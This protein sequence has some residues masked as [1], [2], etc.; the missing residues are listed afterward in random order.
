MMTVFERIPDIFVTKY[1]PEIV[2]WARR[3]SVAPMLEIEL[4]DATAA[5]LVKAGMAAPKVRITAVI[6][7]DKVFV[8]PVS[9]WDAELI[10]H[11]CEQLPKLQRE[12]ADPKKLVKNTRA[13]FERI[14]D[15]FIEA[16]DWEIK[17]WGR[18]FKQVG[19]T[20]DILLRRPHGQPVLLDDNGQE[21]MI[22]VQLWAERPRLDGDTVELVIVPQTEL[23]EKKIRQHAEMIAKYGAPVP[24]KAI[25]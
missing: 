2:A 12:K 8:R 22:M 9:E 17:K 7:N 21:P 11:H 20:C 16:Y 3:F 25:H 10:R 24:R 5:W 13:V 23:D 1:N 18:N 6:G 14:P 19:R 4:R 15:E